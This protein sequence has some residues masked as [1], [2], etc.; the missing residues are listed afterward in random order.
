[1]VWTVSIS[2]KKAS[3]EGR[4][5]RPPATPLLKPK[6]RYAGMITAHIRAPLRDFPRR[7]KYFCIFS[8]RCLYVVAVHTKPYFSKLR[9]TWLETT[10]SHTMSADKRTKDE[11]KDNLSSYQMGRRCADKRRNIARWNIVDHGMIIPSS[12]YKPQS[13]IGDSPDIKPAIQSSPRC[14]AFQVRRL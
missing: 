1:M 8:K 6:S 7:P 3:H 13:L 2:G 5:K 9:N 10:S 4:S 11:R 12:R 14:W